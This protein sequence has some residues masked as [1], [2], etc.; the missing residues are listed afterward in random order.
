M[1]SPKQIAA[2]TAVYKAYKTK[3]KVERKAVSFAFKKATG[4]K[5]SKKYYAIPIVKQLIKLT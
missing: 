2:L 1:L 3:K 4:V 5:L